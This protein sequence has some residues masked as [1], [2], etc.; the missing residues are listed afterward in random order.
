[1]GWGGGERRAGGGGG[2]WDSLTPQTRKRR[3]LRPQQE[4]PSVN[5]DRRPN[6]LNVEGDELVFSNWTRQ[7]TFSLALYSLSQK[8]RD[9][10]DGVGAG[11]D[12]FPFFVSS[13][14]LTRSGLPSRR[15]QV[16]GFR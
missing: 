13:Y 5:T 14:E 1:M 6:K 12:A 15:P 2:S 16:T 10:G 9:E 8:L 11:R 7:R 3:A 4:V